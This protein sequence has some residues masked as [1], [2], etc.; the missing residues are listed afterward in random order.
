MI[1]CLALYPASTSASL[2]SISHHHHQYTITV[3][4][5]QYVVRPFYPC[6]AKVSRTVHLPTR[7]L[8]QSWF[9]W[10][11]Y[12]LLLIALIYLTTFC[13]SGDLSPHVSDLHRRFTGAWL[14]LLRHLTPTMGQ[15]ARDT[16]RLKQSLLLASPESMLKLW[17]MKACHNL[18][19]AR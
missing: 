2:I 9:P 5:S 16:S 11:R 10:Y 13:R 17:R 19:G 1:W 3:N 14:S 8:P 7:F 18:V 6:P 12:C 15:R 4:S